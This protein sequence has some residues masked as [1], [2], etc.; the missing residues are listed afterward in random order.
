M[1]EDKYRITSFYPSGGKRWE[2]EYKNGQKH[3]K[4]M[5]W[6]ENGEKWWD[7]G[8]KDGKRPLWAEDNLSKGIK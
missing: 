1:G 5:S 2:R 3:G 4:D 7:V 8:Y 6:L